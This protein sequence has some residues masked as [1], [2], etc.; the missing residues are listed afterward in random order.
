MAARQTS[1]DAGSETAEV[2]DETRSTEGADAHARAEADRPPTPEEEAAAPTE[3]S[4]EVAANYEA[5]LERG[6]NVRGEG[7]IET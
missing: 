7:Q 5:A 2:S 6:A 1:G 3:V 4:D